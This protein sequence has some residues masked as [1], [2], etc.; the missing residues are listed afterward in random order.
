M[1]PQNCEYSVKGKENLELF[2]KLLLMFGFYLFIF[3]VFVRTGTV[4]ILLSSSPTAQFMVGVLHWMLIE[5][6]ISESMIAEWGS[7][8]S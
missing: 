5:L 2:L 8:L 7:I 1:S 4:D 6:S 3:F